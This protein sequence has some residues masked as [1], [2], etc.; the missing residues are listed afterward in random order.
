MHNRADFSSTLI[1]GPLVNNL[2]WK[3][4]FHILQIFLV[5]LLILTIF[6]CPETTYLRDQRY[7]TDI[8][9]VDVL[10]DLAATEKRAR[11]HTELALTE[12][13]S[14]RAVPVEKTFFQSMAVFTGVYTT[15]NIIKLV[16]APFV[17]LLNPGA[18]YTIIT[19]GM[20]QAWYV[21]IAITQAGLFSAPP[22]SLDAAQLGY[23]SVGPLVGGL[24]GSILIGLISD[25]T[26]KWASKRNM[27]V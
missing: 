26:A 18:C 4:A 1:S 17:S 11:E 8:V 3:W 12:S 23:L 27:G 16:I 7:D 19:S 20:L 13:Q 14:S 5:V 6:F 22:Y 9:Q 10:E 15:D 24:L 2:G 25:P 21:T